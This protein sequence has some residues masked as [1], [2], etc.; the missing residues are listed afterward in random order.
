MPVEAPAIFIDFFDNNSEAQA[1]VNAISSGLVPNDAGA[2]RDYT[3]QADEYQ[4]AFIN[5]PAKTLRLLAPA[6]SGK[7]Q[8]VVNRVLAQVQGGRD[9]GS[10]LILT[11]DNA[12]ATSLRQK[13]AEGLERYAVKAKPYVTT[14]NAFGYAM[15]RRDLS[16]LYAGLGV[17]E[18]TRKDQFEA[19]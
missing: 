10:Y 2:L 14:L 17:G 18:N 4:Q 5:S 11:F 8:S 3:Y 12:A 6:G 7:T 19:V 9:L 13:F 1:R 16:S 15:M